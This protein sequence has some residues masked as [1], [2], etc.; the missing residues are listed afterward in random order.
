MG[1]RAQLPDYA[2]ESK[3]SM[4]EALFIAGVDEVGM[5]CLAGPVVAAA[6][7]LDKDRIP[8]GIDDSKRLS[9]RRREELSV[10]IRESA[11]GFAL[12]IAEVDEI[13]SINILQAGRLAMLRAV[14]QIRPAPQ[15]LLIDGRVKL[16]VSVP[17]QS[18]IK[19][20]QI[21]VSIA[22][23]SIL[24]KVHRDQLMTDL[25]GIYPG[26]GFAENKGYGSVSHR[27]FLGSNGATPIH[28]KSFSWTP[29]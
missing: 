3:L 7:I 5:G 21:S 27:R 6:V 17:Q 10:A 15:S 22:A 25:D 11:I 28:R 14:K 1:G 4:R 12:G 23:A 18:I 8:K 13:D 29:V 26:Y 2:F 20:D 24:A 19:G 9:S 16:D